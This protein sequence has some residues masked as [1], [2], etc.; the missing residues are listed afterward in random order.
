MYDLTIIPEQ[1]VEATDEMIAAYNEA[2]KQFQDDHPLTTD[3]EVVRAMMD[4]DIPVSRIEVSARWGRRRL[5]F[6]RRTYQVCHL[7]RRGYL[8]GDELE[9]IG[10]RIEK[11]DRHSLGALLAA[12][13]RETER[14]LAERRQDV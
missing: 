12:L 6:L 4:V 2:W 13:N 5:G 10:N 9:R 7:M 11:A 14:V 8:T 3:F 1:W